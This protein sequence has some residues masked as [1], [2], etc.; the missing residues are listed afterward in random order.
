MTRALF[1]FIFIIYASFNEV[2]CKDLSTDKEW[3]LLIFTQSWPATVCK[4]WKEHD[5]THTCN[6]PTNHDSWTIHGIW[7]TKL[8]TIGPAFCNR[9]WHF[10][11]EQVRP[12][13]KTLEQLWTNVESGTS[14]YALWAHEW[15]KHGTCA[16]VLE[17]LNSEIKYFTMGL[18]W[19]RKF[20]MYNILQEASITPS[21]SNQYSVLD[22]HN[23]VKNRLGI[24]PMI[25]C[26]KEDD[27]SYLGE[28]RICFTKD[29]ELRDCNGVSSKETMI[30]RDVVLTNCNA[31]QGVIY[32]QS[33]SD[34]IYV[35]LYRLISWLQWLTL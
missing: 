22:I 11:P 30:G 5:Q 6:L 34:K 31:S 24:N 17:P 33:P 21:N 27:K 14:T 3:D 7:P 26:R 32:L 16:A 19:I 15:N 13:E 4:E 12:I 23:A 28:I 1:Y 9:T 20:M 25:E 18:N 35:H 10:D 2:Y 8:G 29:L